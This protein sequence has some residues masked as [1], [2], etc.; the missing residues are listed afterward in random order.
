MHAYVVGVE[1]A[2]DGDVTV[3]VEAGCELFALV[4]EVVLD[5]VA[6]RGRVDGGG[7]AG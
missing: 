3:A 7:G 6:G 5:G 2:R 1:F 4:G